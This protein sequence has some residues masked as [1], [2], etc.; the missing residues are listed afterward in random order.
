MSRSSCLKRILMKAIV[1]SMPLKITPSRTNATRHFSTCVVSNY[2]SV[3][4]P[5]RGKSTPL[6]NVSN[7]FALFYDC[8]LITRIYSN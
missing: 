6:R 3:E 5:F 2:H 4:T 7:G 1:F 8:F